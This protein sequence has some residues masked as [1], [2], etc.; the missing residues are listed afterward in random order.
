VLSA[1]W[2]A[3]TV[4]RSFQ[5]TPTSTSFSTSARFVDIPVAA[6]TAE[7]LL[8]GAVLAW[9]ETTPGVWAPLPFEHKNI[10]SSI[11]SAYDVEIR[12]GSLRLLYSRFD[13]NNPTVSQN[14]LSLTQPNRNFRWV[15]IPPAGISLVGALP[16]HEGV[17]ATIAALRARGVEVRESR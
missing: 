12:P 14:P 2:S 5:I 6:L 10:S 11:V 4:Q 16:V 3:N 9:L 7:V 8:G 1:D 13:I 17:D 15:V